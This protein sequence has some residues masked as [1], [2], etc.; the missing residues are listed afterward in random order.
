MV[1]ISPITANENGLLVVFIQGQIMY[2]YIGVSAH[3]LIFF[4]ALNS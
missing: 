3:L 1:I 4:H 2:M